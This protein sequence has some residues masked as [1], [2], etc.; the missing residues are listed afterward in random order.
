MTVMV[1]EDEELLLEAITKKLKLAN[2]EVISCTGGLQALAFLEEFPKLPDVIW[3]DYYLKDLNGLEFMH[4]LRDNPNFSKIPVF[5]VSNSAS[6]EKVNSM[7]AL[8]V[9]KY[10]VKAEHRLEEIVQIIKDSLDKGEHRDLKKI[11]IVEDDR[12]LLKA[13]K[14][15]FGSQGF[16]VLE[17]FDGEEGLKLASTEKPDLILLDI[18]MPKMNGNEMIDK[19]RELMLDKLP[20]VVILTNL[21]QPD[22][23][24]YAKTVLIKSN[25]DLSE[26]VEKVKEELLK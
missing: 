26:V 18:L 19:L 12:T 9:S 4:K 17:A 8:G 23:S 24:P 21:P 14:I 13:L 16:E 25:T 22:Y 20:P 2:F 7:L 6:N 5:V 3:L 10:L 11:L 1:I 15:K